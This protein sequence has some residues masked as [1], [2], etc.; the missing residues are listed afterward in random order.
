MMTWLSVTGERHG[1]APSREEIRAAHEW[2]HN[3]VA[4]GQN[5]RK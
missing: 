4:E 3:L 2:G 5:E 1:D